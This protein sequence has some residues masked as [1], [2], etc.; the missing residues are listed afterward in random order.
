MHL[1]TPA[2]PLSEGTSPGWSA[3]S[4]QRATQQHRRQLSKRSTAPAGPHYYIA[5]RTLYSYRPVRVKA[6]EF[7]ASARAGKAASQR[8]TRAC[9]LASGAAH[10]RHLIG[11]H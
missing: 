11:R 5:Q 10:V 7:A 2:P 6:L 4:C 9:L 1:D 3:H 8:C